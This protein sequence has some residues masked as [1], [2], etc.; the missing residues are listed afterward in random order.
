MLERLFQLRQRGTTVGTELRAGVTTFLTMA[1]IL[2]VNPQIL[3]QAGMPVADVAVA[4]AVAAAVA[5]LVM[6]LYA[7]FPFALA[8]GMGL[9]A[10]FTFGI[11]RGLGVSWQLA[12]T[13]VFLEGILFVALSVTGL[14]TRLLDMI[15][16]PI[17][18]AIMA[19]IGLLL[20]MIGLQNAGIM[21]SSADTVVALGNLRAPGPLLALAGTLIT[22]ALMAVRFRGAILTGILGVTVSSWVLGLSAHPEAIFSLPHLPRETFLAFD[23]SDFSSGILLVTVVALLFVDIFDTAGTL[24]GVGQLGGFVDD[25]GE[26]PGANRAFTS[27]AVGT[28]VG[29]AFGTSTVTTFVESA[30]GV[31]EGGRTGLT[32]VVVAM[33]L[34]LALFVTP[35]LTAVPPFATAPALITVGAL[36]MRGA[37]ELKW[38]DP[39]VALPAFLTI[40][41]MPATYS[42]ATGI[43]F[44]LISWVAVHLLTGRGREVHPLLYALTLALVAFYLLY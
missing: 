19:G 25:R 24:I 15:P 11:V 6:G 30:T 9:N 1:Y 17:K 29:A 10:Y 38:N 18:V 32:A 5:T 36:M 28:V 16:R 20:A 40:V 35:I 23:F 39:R 37:T 8:P 27:D 4:T 22:A 44:G 42:I 21:V 13:A 14:R 2:F 12:L 3:S 34:L 31:E 26:M 41:L 43:S 33:L 7:N